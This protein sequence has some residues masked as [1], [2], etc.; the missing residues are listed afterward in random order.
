MTGVVNDRTYTQ[1]LAMRIVKDVFTPLAKD[2]PPKLDIAENALRI[3]I[4]HAHKDKTRGYCVQEA[5]KLLEAITERGKYV[6]GT[7]NAKKWDREI[8]DAYLGLDYCFS[9]ESLPPPEH[10]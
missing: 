5:E 7:P 3:F 6:D 2:F 4:R 10:S 1:R 8:F 9:F